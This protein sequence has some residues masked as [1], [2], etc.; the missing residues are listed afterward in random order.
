M[1]TDTRVPTFT[2]LIKLLTLGGEVATLA[3]AKLGVD[4][5][6]I[7]GFLTHNDILPEW[8]QSS[9]SA[10][11][12]Q[13]FIACVKQLM[14][15]QTTWLYW[16]H[17]GQTDTGREYTWDNW[18]HDY[19][20][21][22][23]CCAYQSDLSLDRDAL[24]AAANDVRNTVVDMYH[25][26]KTVAQHLKDAAD[27][28]AKAE[29]GLGVVGTILVGVGLYVGYQYLMAS[30]AGERLYADATRARR[31]YKYLKTTKVG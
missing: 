8:L 14:A 25:T 5:T 19:A 18:L 7:T 4:G 30:A 26:A 29:K 24:N 22:V 11:I 12:T 27:T 10:A 9:V 28:A 31:S 2:E 3:A 21:A 13:N 6:F 16:A 17:T 15:A 23:N 1:Y 20:E